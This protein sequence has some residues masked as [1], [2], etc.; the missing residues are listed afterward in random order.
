MRVRMGSVTASSERVRV[1]IADDSVLMRE[2]TAR[3]L[4]ESGLDVVGQ[5][6]DGDDLMLK[7]RS[8]SPDVAIVDIRMPPSHTDEGLRAAKAIRERYPAT[9][10]L[11]LSQYVETE[12]ATQL[13]SENAEGIGYLLKDRIADIGDFAA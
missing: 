12:Y 6:V 2:G 7:V 8:Y 9:G 11:V 10:V 5:A 1:V 13:L 3:L 4:E